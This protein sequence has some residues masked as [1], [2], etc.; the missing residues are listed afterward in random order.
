MRKFNI[1]E[2]ILNKLN[3]LYQRKQKNKIIYSINPR[4]NL[5]QEQI[6]FL[7][8]LKNKYSFLINS[9]EIEILNLFKNYNLKRLMN[10]YKCYIED[11]DNPRR[12]EGSSYKL[13]CD[14]HKNNKI[15]LKLANRRKKFKKPKNQKIQKEILNFLKE[16]NKNIDLGYYLNFNESK[17]KILKSI[18]YMSLRHPKLANEIEEYY[19][20]I[21]I[22]NNIQINENQKDK[23]IKKVYCYLFDYIPKCKAPDCNKETRFTGGKY[24]K[25]CSNICVMKDPEHYQRHIE[26]QRSFEVN[27]KRSES[28]KESI[29]TMK[30]NIKKTSILR[31][32]V[33]NPAQRH[34]RNLDKLNKDYIEKNFIN[35]DKNFLVKKF[36]NFYGYYWDAQPYKYLKKFKIEYKKFQSSSQAEDEII[37]F[38]KNIYKGKILKNDREIIKPKEL[39]IYIPE[40]NLAIEFDGLYWHSF[41]QK[42]LKNKFKFKHLKKTKLAEEKGINLL[43]IFENEW[44]DPIKQDIWKSII[45]Y[46]LG[47]VKQ[48][49]FARKLKIKEINNKE[50][51]EF[52]EENHLQGEIDSKINLGLFKDQKLISCMTFG[53]SRF[54]RNFEYELYRFASLK[55]SSCVGCAQRLLKYFIK[56]YKP[57]SIISYANRRWASS[58]S[59]VYRSLNFNFIRESEPNYYYFKNDLKLLSRNK[60]QKYKIKSMIQNQESEFYGMDDKKSEIDLMF[61]A[62]YRRIYDAGQLTYIYKGEENEENE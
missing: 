27:K 6:N 2:S 29:N 15:K 19:S 31:Y 52:F 32:G 56:T 62:N 43:H 4:I 20:K 22:E 54:N 30:E 57:K 51:K 44:L 53:K 48:R 36:M 61:E 50:A 33:E 37:D 17:I 14:D 7:Q 58:L 26:I 38:I 40:K 1:K 24:K 5:N 39:D 9:S 42:K 18:K 13:T 35:E 49:Y 3:F 46:K 34:L 16:K 11:C 45:S 23:F 60:F 10:D 25:Y 8:K 55:Y 28:L 12:V 41:N 47:I 59:N 21:T